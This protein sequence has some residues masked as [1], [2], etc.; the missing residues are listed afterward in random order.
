[1]TA[2]ETNIISIQTLCMGLLPEIRG[3]SPRIAELYQESGQ[4]DHY[5]RLAE[6]LFHHFGD[7]ALAVAGFL[8]GI[9]ADQGKR[10]S[11]LVPTETQEI[12]SGWDRL[13]GLLPATKK[14]DR[15]LSTKYLQEAYDDVDPR[16][17]LLL[18]HER[19]DRF[20]P[21]R[22]LAEWG[23]RFRRHPTPF[24]GLGTFCQRE[25]P[26]HERYPQEDLGRFLELVVAPIARELGLWQEH[27]ILR[28]AALARRDPTSFQALARLANEHHESWGLERLKEV[29]QELECCPAFPSNSVD[30]Y[31]GWRHLA[32]M[33]EQLTPFDKD[34]WLDHLG[35]CAF[36]TILCDDEQACY[37]T[38]GAVHEV[39]DFK[40]EFFRDALGQPTRS[41]YR[42]LHTAI[43]DPLASSDSYLKIRITT[44][45]D[46]E[47]RFDFAVRSHLD[48]LKDKKKE[49]K[50][51]EI[52]INLDGRPRYISEKATVLELA[53]VVDPKLVPIIQGAKIHGTF[54]DQFHGLR[55]GDAVEFILGKNQ[56]FPEDWEARVEAGSVARIRTA[57][58]H[59]YGELL[60]RSARHWLNDELGSIIIDDVF[61][62]VLL[63]TAVAQTVGAEQLQQ[64]GM[65]WWLHQLGLVNRLLRSEL[66]PYPPK[67]T[68][69]L[70]KRI[71]K[72]ATNALKGVRSLVPIFDVQPEEV[73]EIERCP[74]CLPNRRSSLAVTRHGGHLTVHREGEPCAHGGSI[75]RW[76]SLTVGQ[77]FHIQMANEPGTMREVLSLLSDRGVNVLELVL[78]MLGQDWGA[79][80][81]ETEAMDQATVA[82]ILDDLPKL[83]HVSKAYGP[84]DEVPSFIAQGFPPRMTEGPWLLS[85]HPEPFVCGPVV[86]EPHHFYGRRSEMHQLYQRT[87]EARSNPTH[88]EHVFVSGPLK[89]GKTSLVQRVQA[90]LNQDRK[91]PSLCVY[92][93]TAIG[94]SWLDLEP[95]LL[96]KLQQ[97]FK[98]IG[99]EWFS[100][101]LRSETTDLWGFL[102]K[103]RT[104]F[105]E[106]AIMMA[107]DEAP[108]LLAQTQREPKA[109]AAFRQF[110]TL[111]HTLG[112]AIV[113]WIGPSAPVDR[114]E[115]E[116]Q[117]ILR[118]S[119]VQIPIQPLTL[120]E[121]REMLQAQKLSLFHR[122]EV[123]LKI[124]QRVHALTNGDPFWNA[125]MGHR[126]W[127]IATASQ[128]AK[129][130]IRLNKRIVEQAK[131]DLVQ[132]S[133]PFKGRLFPSGTKEA[134]E[135][136]LMALLFGLA[137]LEGEGSGDL[138]ETPLDGIGLGDLLIHLETKQ[139]EIQRQEA[140]LRLDEMTARG[141]VRVDAHGKWQFAA[142]LVKLFIEHQIEVKG[143]EW[144]KSV[145]KEE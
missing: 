95:I 63:E 76:Q 89:S 29:R 126:M 102:R 13:V 54:V 61:L 20:D 134:R 144:L 21:E 91:R 55:S 9:A 43:L 97:Q 118:G 96:E 24:E 133:T 130:R 72:A 135:R 138:G 32:T 100:S 109:M 145:E 69:D 51:H 77:V 84:G 49:W 106:V 26:V 16:S 93:K 4:L 104:R 127:R 68:E 103:F 2:N 121:T 42:A 35:S 99:F 142:P 74:K 71:I 27:T 10:L 52:Q 67:I 117:T 111:F 141:G 1:M 57:L 85:K 90:I 46:E 12:L 48:G 132:Y 19:L 131:T 59:G 17:A 58:N 108:R 139:I 94:Q 18:V 5:T 47:K 98:N 136:Q 70:A 14:F 81:L 3:L 41:G 115:P 45:Q 62:D 79:A 105:G 30:S 25:V 39:F 38:L 28:D 75:L 125:H 124:A 34:M 37:L 53:A 22:Q 110:M 128:P 80:R 23:R 114:L 88:G 36:I 73:Q 137:K 101:Q 15:S 87:L 11:N 44:K 65:P 6:T 50:G 86:R 123:G 83:R 120:Q 66:T 56:P 64:Q 8:H 122:I 40:Q 113:V 60:E 143:W 119:S 112:G 82:A 107:V 116:L 33:A 78:R 7:E 31:W 92:H 140:R 129:N